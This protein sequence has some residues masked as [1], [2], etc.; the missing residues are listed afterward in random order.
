MYGERKK[1]DSKET[2]SSLDKW[3]SAVGR[4]CGGG[5][6]A[7]NAGAGV[8]ESVGGAGASRTRAEVKSAHGS[9]DLS[10]KLRVERVVRT[11]GRGDDRGRPK[12]SVATPRVSPQG[13]K[14]MSTTASH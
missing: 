8:R 9:R 12:G 14:K 3:S 1:N 13:L 5:N 10:S 6:G 4:R 7:V 2:W 11:S